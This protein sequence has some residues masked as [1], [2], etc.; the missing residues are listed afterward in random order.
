MNYKQIK[1]ANQTTKDK[2]KTI[3]YIFFFSF[4]RN[5]SY[6]FIIHC[7]YEEIKSVYDV[8]FLFFIFFRG[9][10]YCYNYNYNYNYIDTNCWIFFFFW[11]L[12]T[13]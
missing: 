13:N 9:V 7:V 3:K 12:M 8:P 11:I 2:G 5:I 4:K 10:C 6:K 1:Q